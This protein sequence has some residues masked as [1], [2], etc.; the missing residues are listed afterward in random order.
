MNAWAVPLRILAAVAMVATDEGAQ[1]EAEEAW[2]AALAALDAFRDAWFAE[3]PDAWT[4]LALR[5][6]GEA[7]VFYDGRGQV[8][9][10]LA[11]LDKRVRAGWQKER[12]EA[13]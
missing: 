12:S 8:E 2:D 4:E 5:V 6:Y 3:Q 1:A 13:A 7:I 9:K 11:V 10:M